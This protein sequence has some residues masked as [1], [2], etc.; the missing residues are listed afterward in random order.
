MQLGQ[1]LVALEVAVRGRAARMHDALGNA[2]VIEM[3]D[4]LAQD[5]IFQQRG[6][7]QP[8]LQRVLVVGDG[9]A[10][11]GGQPARRRVDAHPIERRVGGVEAQLRSS[12]ARLRR[13]VG[14]CEGATGYAGIGDVA[15]RARL[16][17][18]GSVAVLCGLSRV[19]RHRRRQLFGTLHFLG[20]G[21]GRSGVAPGRPADGRARSTPRARGTQR[22]LGGI[23][24]R[25]L[26]GR[27]LLGG[28]G[29]PRLRVRR[30][31]PRER[32]ASTERGKVVLTDRTSSP[33]G[34]RRQDTDG[35]TISAVAAR[36]PAR[37]AR[38]RWRS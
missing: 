37:R 33:G 18:C 23:S 31:V 21:V 20:E 25:E 16:R 17:R 24:G 11:V 27:R 35:Q 19:E 26:G 8:G 30:T 7:A 2:L 22:F 6:T 1:R 12:V 9:H 32:K 15:H 14:F 29:A 28:H 36:R 3:R 10:L 38:R 4:L 34:D 13:R 5:E